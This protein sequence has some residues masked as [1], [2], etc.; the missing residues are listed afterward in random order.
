MGHRSPGSVNMNGVRHCLQQG[1]YREPKV[2]NVLEFYDFIRVPLNV[3]EFVL[4]A[5]EIL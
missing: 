2:F 4:N 5:L 3:L 1:S